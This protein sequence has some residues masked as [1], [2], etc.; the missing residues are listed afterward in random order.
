V[1]LGRP[2]VIGASRKRFIGAL[3][4]RAEQDRAAGTVAVNVM[5]FE[6]GAHMFRVHDVAPTRDALAVASATVDESR[7][8][9][10]DPPRFT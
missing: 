6:R 9:A 8:E 7:V 10:P 5:A 3:T 2:V 4:G 1:A